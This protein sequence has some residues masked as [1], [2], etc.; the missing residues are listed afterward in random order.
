MKEPGKQL[1]ILIGFT[2]KSRRM[3]AESLERLKTQLLAYG[4]D[5]VFVIRQKKSEIQSYLKEN[6][7][8]SHAVLME[9]AGA[10]K[11]T[12]NELADLVDERDINIILVLTDEKR[13][14]IGFLTTIYAAGITGAIFENKV[15]VPEEKIADFLIR[16]RNR[17]EAREYYHIDTKNI[18]IRSLT[19]KMYDE[20]CVKL[21]DD[22]L[23]ENAM[24]RLLYIAESLN[25]YQMGSFLE[26]LPERIK[27]ELGSYQEYA[28]LISQLKESRVYVE[29]RRPRK[30]KS[31]SDDTD[32][33]ENAKIAVENAGF[34][35]ELFGD[36]DTKTD[37]KKL[38][39]KMFKEPE[40]KEPD[41][42]KPNEDF[43]FL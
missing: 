10:S 9:S 32:F 16:P 30:L 36:K 23:G 13:K 27:D 11:W 6:E 25:P 3:D 2:Q 19:A 29:Y 37:K 1:K 40:D 41:E 33:N 43:F 35:A 17:R 34:D 28:Q 21:F 39:S 7:S 22:S 14:D 5:P 24:S 42:E 4:Y 18:S 8:C 31:L 38:F 12:E 15:G 26:K 20:L